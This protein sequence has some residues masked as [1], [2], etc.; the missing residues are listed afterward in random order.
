M[1]L[2]FPFCQITRDVVTSSMR[3]QPRL[4]VCAFAAIIIAVA[5]LIGWAFYSREPSYQ[6]KRLSIW[7]DE[8]ATNYWHNNAGPAAKAQAAVRHIGPD[9]VPF[10]LDAI[11][12]KPSSLKKKLRQIFPQSWH[13]KLFL[14]DKTGDTR[15]MGA[16]GVV[17][18]GTNAPPDIIPKLMMIITNHPHRDSRH[19]AASA[20]CSLGP[21]AE[22]AIPFLVKCLKSDDPAIRASA[23]IGLGRVQRQPDV[24]VPALVNYLKFCIASLDT[25]ETTSE[26]YGAIMSLRITS[27]NARAALPLLRPLLNHK[28]W[29]IRDEATNAVQHIDDGYLYRPPL[30]PPD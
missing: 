14:E 4:F 25:S 28:D 17:A 20:L 29:N 12:T 3:R 5:G 6:G 26:T 23:A 24:A 11:A 18:L 27:T 13:R 1:P 2:S 9:G 16:H 19:R 8:Y 15:K 21:A 10:L 30:R 7:V 22:P